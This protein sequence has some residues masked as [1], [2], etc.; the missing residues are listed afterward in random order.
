[1]NTDTELMMHL[2]GGDDGAF[3]E[4]LHRHYGSVLNLAYRYLGSREQAED[5]TQDVFLKVYASR[6]RYQPR[7]KFTTWLFRIA[8]NA[9]LNDRR[10]RSLQL[11]G[12]QTSSLNN[13]D[14]IDPESIVPL[15]ALE[16]QELHEELKRALL[17]LPPNQRTALILNKLQGLSYAEVAEAM[18]LSAAAVKS[19]LSRARHHLKKLLLPYLKL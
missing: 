11:P 18:A 19:L 10:D 13:R 16:K 4:L 1:M 8:V 12:P 15:A 7:A 6:K 14:P 3:E 2:K 5:L 17:K 9:C